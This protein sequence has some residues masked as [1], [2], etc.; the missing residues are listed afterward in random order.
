MNSK[1]LAATAAITAGVIIS[2]AFMINN[3][4]NDIYSQIVIQ[5]STMKD[6]KASDIIVGMIPESGTILSSIFLVPPTTDY[7]TAYM[8]AIS[9]FE[10]INPTHG[11]DF[12]SY[13]CVYAD[14]RIDFKN[15]ISSTRVKDMTNIVE[16][17]RKKDIRKVS[18]YEVGSKGSSGSEGKSKYIY[19]DINKKLFNEKSSV[20]SAY[21]NSITTF[22]IK[23]LY[24]FDV[25][26]LDG[27]LS[28]H[29]NKKE[30]SRSDK[31]C[32]IDIDIKVCPNG[33]RK[34]EGLEKIYDVRNINFDV[35]NPEVDVYTRYKKIP[36]DYKW[37]TNIFR[38][39]KNK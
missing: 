28:L 10:N 17:A 6:S 21:E 8:N 15:V 11:R 1:I 2:S 13:H 7:K 30:F 14:G 18:V 26:K 19:L 20:D 24:L 36:N 34:L 33:E 32:K 27:N 23:D 12:N 5:D 22:G 35:F 38:I 4:S 3:K 31:N 25:Y 16:D 39:I 29:A 9:Y 37:W